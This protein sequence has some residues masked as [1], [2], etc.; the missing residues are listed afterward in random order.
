MVQQGIA[1]NQTQYIELEQLVA[2]EESEVEYYEQEF[3]EK[4]SALSALSA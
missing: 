1:A 3:K 4:E 2:V